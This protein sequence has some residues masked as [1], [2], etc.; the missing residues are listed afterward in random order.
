MTL[1]NSHA[2]FTRSSFGFISVTFELLGPGQRSRKFNVQL[3]N[4]SP[5]LSKITAKLAKYGLIQNPPNI[6]PFLIK[7]TLVSCCTSLHNS[8]GFVAQ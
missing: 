7:K 5:N 8:V 2:Q 1:N 6:L 4:M 3:F